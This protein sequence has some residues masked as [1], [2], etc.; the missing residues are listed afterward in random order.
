ML[1]C[2]MSPSA[3]GRGAKEPA[4]VDSRRLKA[5]IGEDNWVPLADDYSAGQ[6]GHTALTQRDCGNVCRRRGTA[7]DSLACLPVD[8]EGFGSGSGRHSV[9]IPVT[10][11][12]KDFAIDMRSRE[13]LMDCYV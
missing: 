5:T 3:P 6:R 7:S 11:P 1:R 10:A 9:G 8:P 4:R 2:R 12:T 13:F